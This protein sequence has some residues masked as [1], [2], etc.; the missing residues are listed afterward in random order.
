MLIETS[1]REAQSRNFSLEL[2]AISGLRCEGSDGNC[3]VCE[4]NTV[5]MADAIVQTMW[6]P[7]ASRSTLES[8]FWDVQ[9]QCDCSDCLHI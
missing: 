6:A 7:A 4:V 1:R 2:A 3:G 9:C 5:N 8:I